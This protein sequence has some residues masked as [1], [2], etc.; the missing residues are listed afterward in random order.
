MHQRAYLADR[1]VP[2]SSIC[3]V[4]INHDDALASRQKMRYLEA[5]GAPMQATESK[6]VCT[7]SGS[8]AFT[9][10][11]NPGGSRTRC[12]E[13]TLQAALTPLSVRADRFQWTW[14]HMHIGTFW[15]WETAKHT[16]S[17][18]GDPLSRPCT[19]TRMLFYH[20]IRLPSSEST[21]TIST[22]LKL[23]LFRVT[24]TPKT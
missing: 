9:R 14:N 16:A 12:A 7:C 15:F 8:S 2:C 1:S 22:L 4:S 24:I 19:R 11:I 20:L 3:Y 10:S 5:D 18:D 6:Y 13:T 23:H 21:T 17:V